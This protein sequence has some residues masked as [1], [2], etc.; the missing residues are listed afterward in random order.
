MTLIC[1]ILGHRWTSRSH[2]DDDGF[3]YD[4]RIFIRPVDY[5]PRCGLT[6]AEAG[7]TDLTHS[8]D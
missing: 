2:K 8:R 3:W 4:H 7:I 5:C 6:K 1:K